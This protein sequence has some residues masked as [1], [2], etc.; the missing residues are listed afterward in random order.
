MIIDSLQGFYQLLQKGKPILAIDYGSKKL[1]IAISDPSH[2]LSMPFTLIAKNSDEDKLKNI[3]QITQNIHACAII[4][5]LPINMDGSNSTQ[6]LKIQQFANKLSQK[7]DLPIYLQ[8]ERLTSKAAN[9]FLKE[10]GLNRKK[11]NELD[12]LT[13]ASMILETSLNRINKYSQF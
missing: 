11:R 5:G 7:T 2:I 13:A 1:G 3:I 10:F 9:N 8:D 6:T 12:D 4:L